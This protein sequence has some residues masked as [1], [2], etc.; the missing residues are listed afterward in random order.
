MYSYANLY[1]LKALKI[2]QVVTMQKQDEVKPSESMK[3]MVE[4][5]TLKELNTQM[6]NSLVY[7]TMYPGAFVSRKTSNIMFL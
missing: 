4:R 7:Y 1:K 3:K 6:K 5:R 2:E